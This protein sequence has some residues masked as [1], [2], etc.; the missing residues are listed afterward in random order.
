MKLHRALSD[1]V[2]RVHKREKEGARERR[3]EL[4]GVV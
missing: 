3:Q 2:I 4:E 1:S